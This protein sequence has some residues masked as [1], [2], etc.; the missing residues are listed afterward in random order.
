MINS[1]DK[2]SEQSGWLE[3][4][5]ETNPNPWTIVSF[6]IPVYSMGKDRDSKTTRNAFMPLFDKYGVDLV[7]TGHDHT[8]ARSKKLYNGET[9]N[10]NEKGTVY[11]VSVSGPKMYELNPLYEKLMAKVAV[12][13]SLFQVISIDGSELKYE[14]YSADGA[15]FD[16]FILNK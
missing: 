12:N 3:K 1:Y 5:L 14:S 16:S 15:L 11:V 6:H 10:D 8:Y 4:I 13:I 9:V 2:V 7:L